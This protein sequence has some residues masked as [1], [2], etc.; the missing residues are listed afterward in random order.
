MYNHQHTIEY[1]HSTTF[2]YGCRCSKN[3]EPVDVSDY[4]FSAK[5]RDGNGKFITDLIIS[6]QQKIGLLHFS[7]PPNTTLPIKT[8][9]MDVRVAKDGVER[10]SNHR[11][12]IIVNRVVT[13]G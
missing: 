1:N 11:V 3:G 13:D 9:Y 10:V 7:L 2:G 6:K 5:I 8:L 4:Q 12:R